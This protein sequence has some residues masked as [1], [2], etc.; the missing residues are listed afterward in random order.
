MLIS[1][2]IFI[3]QLVEVPLVSVDIT[4]EL[5]LQLKLVKFICLLVNLEYLLDLLSSFYQLLSNETCYDSL[6]LHVFNR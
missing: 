1:L 3:T 5:L 2:T 6:L 4:I